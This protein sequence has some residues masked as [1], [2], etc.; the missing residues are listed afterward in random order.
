MLHNFI[1][2]I[3]A[4]CGVAYSLTVSFNKDELTLV[5]TK[6]VELSSLDA[7]ELE[8]IS[9]DS[10]DELEIDIRTLILWGEHN[11]G[12][13]EKF[14]EKVTHQKKLNAG[15]IKSIRQFLSGENIMGPAASIFSFYMHG[16]KSLVLTEDN[17]FS[18]IW[19]IFTSSI[20]KSNDHNIQKLETKLSDKGNNQVAHDARALLIAL[21]AQDFSQERLAKIFNVSQTTVSRFINK[22]AFCLKLILNIRAYYMSEKG[23]LLTQ[24]VVFKQMK[25]SANNTQFSAHLKNE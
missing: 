20:N 1:Y 11:S 10:D 4:T 19:Y 2:M 5:K 22:K 6:V 25:Q 17:I 9:R 8:Q 16:G 3:V 18:S 15:T 14:W 23:S 24:P 7:L 21:N 12:S 13:L